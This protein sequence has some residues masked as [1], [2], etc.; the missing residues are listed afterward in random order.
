MRCRSPVNLGIWR[1]HLK[2]DVVHYS[3]EGPAFYPFNILYFRIYTNLTEVPE[4][5]TI[6]AEVV[7]GGE[8]TLFPLLTMMMIM[9]KR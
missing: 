8:L 9:R 5:E 7:R 6:R 4:A 3:S 1:I 2:R